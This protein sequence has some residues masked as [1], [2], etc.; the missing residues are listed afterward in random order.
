MF[1]RTLIS[2]CVLLAPAACG[3]SDG[4]ST[5]TD[6]TTPTPPAAVGSGVFDSS[7]AFVKAE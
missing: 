4:S 7:Q 5:G 6:T 1:P 3:G 2:T